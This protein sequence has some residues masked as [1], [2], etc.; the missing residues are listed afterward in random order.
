LFVTVGGTYPTYDQYLKVY[1]PTGTLQTQV[2]IPAQGEHAAH[3]LVVGAD[4]K[5]SI[6]NGVQNPWLSTYDGTSWSNLTYT[7]YWPS[8]NM[9]LTTYLW[10]GLAR[11]GNIV[12]ANDMQ[13]GS[14]G[15]YAAGIVRFNLSTGTSDR[16]VSG[17]PMI[18]T[19]LGQD[20]KLYGLDN[21]NEVIVYDPASGTQLNALGLPYTINGVG[22]NF[23]DLTVNSAGEI[24]AADGTNSRIVKF[25][26]SGTV[27]AVYQLAKPSGYFYP[28]TP[29]DVDL[30]PDGTSLAIGT[31]GA[32]VFQMNADF[33]NMT[34]YWT[35]GTNSFVAFQE[36]S[37]PFVSVSGGSITEG[38]GYSVLNFT[39][40][41][42]RA[43]DQIVS[44]NYSTADGTA[45]NGYDYGGTGGT[46]TFA[47]GETS[48]TVS[49]S[50]YGD[51]IVENDE[52]FTMTL[53]N[54]VN[55]AIA[56]GTAT[57]TIRNDDYPIVSVS[58][59]TAAEGNSGTTPFNFT[60][61]LSQP[62]PFTVFVQYST[63][64]GTA[65]AGSDYTAATQS[66]AF[67]SG[68]TSKTVTINVTGDTTME[69]D[70]TFT[71]NLQ[72]P[73]NCT[74]GTGTAT[75]T[76]TNDDFPTISIG[77]VAAFEGNSG[78][79]A[80]A[81]PLTLS[82]AAP[83][84]VTVNYST[85][86]GTATAGSDYTSATGS[87][88][89]S[90]GQTSK[91]V[92]VNVS[93]DTVI[94]NDETFTVTLSNPTNATIGTGTATGTIRNEDFPALGIVGGIAPEGNS[95]TTPL[96]FT[97]TL[98]EPAPMPL[99][100]T[101]T[102]SN[103]TATSGTD[104]SSAGG[105]LTF[106]PGETS[107]T[108][109]VDVTGDT[110]IEADETFTMTAY[111]GVVAGGGGSGGQTAIG[112]IINDDYPAVAVGDATV[113]EGNSG[114]TAL[115][116]T[117]TLSAPAPWP[118]TVDYTTADG[119]AAAG[120]DYVTTNG[121]LTFAAGETSKTVTVNVTGD[122]LVESDESI[123]LT[124]SNP[125][126]ATLATAAATGNIVND[127]YSVVSVAGGSVVEGDSGSATLA[128]TITLDQPAPWPV[129]VDYA[130]ANGT[131]TAGSD[132]T[133]ASGALTFAP[134][135]TSKT[136][137]IDVV[138]D[139]LVE[140]DETFTLNLSNPTGGTLA[141]VTGAGTI[142]NDD[143]P[144]AS[145]SNSSVVEGSSG[146][147]ALTFMVTLSQPAP[148]PVT[149]DFA[150]ADGTAAAGSDYEAA[151]G[152]LT[153]AAGETSKAITINVT[154]DNV[155]E[156]DET[157]TL[158]LSN[159][160]NASLEAATAAGTIVN[161]DYSAIS[162]G[163]A[164]IG[165]GNSGANALT[166]TVTLDHPASWAVT[167]N[168]STNDATATAGSDFTPASGTLSFAPGEMTRTVSVNV[169][170]DT[171]P[172][173]DETFS[174]DL[175]G[176]T[177]G[178]LETATASGTIIND[179]YPAV[180]IVDA[181]VIEGNSG[182]STLT[183]TVTLT[184]PA[185]FTVSVAYTT[186]DGTATAGSDYATA[187]GTITFAVGETSKT[188][189]VN[190]NGD[191]LVETD[192]TLTVALSAP[193]N[194]TLGTD[195]A[196]GAIVNDDLPAVSLA[197][198]SVT[199][200]NSGSTTITFTITLDQPA[201]WTV[202]VDFATVDGTAVAGS[203]YAA[204]S[205]TSTFAAGET[206]KTFTVNVNGD[207]LVEPDEAFTLAL[208]NPT[209]ATLGTATAL[210]AILND[211]FPVAAVNG[212]AVTEG[213]S[214]TTPLTFTVTLSQ[215]APWPVTVNFATADGSAT[216]GS[217]YQ[218]ASG[219]LTFAPGETSK[220]IVVN[221]VGDTA[222]ESDEAFTLTLSSPNNA[223]LGIATATGTIVNDD[224]P[225]VNVANAQ[226]TEGDIPYPNGTPQTVQMPFVISLS[227]SFT[228]P[229]DVSYTTIAGTATAGTDFTPVT[230]TVRI[231]PGLTQ[232][233]VNVPA[234]AD[235]QIEGIE[236]F[237]FRIT[238]ATF[239]TLGTTD[240]V[241]TIVDNDVPP[242]VTQ[243][244]TSPG[245]ESTTA[246]QMGAWGSYNPTGNVTVTWNF[247]DGTTLTG[248]P[249]TLLGGQLV[250]H[251][252]AD[253]GTYTVTVTVTDADRGSASRSAPVVVQN[254]APTVGGTVPPTI[255][256]LNPATFSFTLGDPSAA[257]QSAG[258][259]TTI[260]WGDGQGATSAL[261]AGTSNF[262]HVFASTGSYTV[263]AWAT[264]KD[265]GLSQTWSQTV[266]VLA[267]G[268]V[269]NDLVVAGTA[270]NDNITVSS[271]NNS[272]VVSLTYNGTAAGNFT[273]PS[274][275][276]VIVYGG[277]GDDRIE[278]KSANISGT[279]YPFPRPVAFHGGAGN[280]NLIASNQ[281]TAPSVLVGGVGND[282]LTGGNGADVLIGGLGV[283]SLTGG[284]G[285]DL[286]IGN[287]VA[288]E[289]DMSAMGLVRSEWA[290]TDNSIT[291]RM[292]H[293]TG[294]LPG[295]LNGAY[296]L[297]T[298]TI[299]EDSAIDDL[300]GSGGTDWFFAAPSGA[301]ADR[302]R[303]NPEYW[304]YL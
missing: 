36:P 122:T 124:L 35:G 116:F 198:G 70:E 255:V 19:T 192:E 109:M 299:S 206:S 171:A 248:S 52:T 17:W 75:G 143:Y 227:S 249:Q 264:D 245:V 265:G 16:I 40:N 115:A 47:P 76:I 156:F 2:T 86:N 154:G 51:T 68:Q 261:P 194:A 25:S 281:S 223:T 74:I 107:K 169:F 26:P 92:T 228:A 251:M 153:F 136:I 254:V 140:T 82:A 48:K 189:T 163:P 288:Y 200:G 174:L 87:V 125:T 80:F 83:F 99:Q 220:S 9:P 4:G 152:T 69:F 267:Y 199:E 127:D 100:V 204:A 211:D 295:G 29:T 259:N 10:G 94:E 176:P 239:A 55:A 97:I 229:I 157:L 45:T 46:V 146:T 276:S 155:A 6:F 274:A 258:F 23:R 7:G 14:E 252:Y 66:V 304:T 175:S 24:Y 297:N 186:S 1:G 128:F 279:N 195:T 162:V 183:Y 234:L 98:S 78:T 60:L 241:G 283:D 63:A 172:E 145:V 88:T 231:N 293:L 18:S 33:T 108:V 218:A 187:S 90:P 287:K 278:A 284:N 190:V 263:R 31:T 294:A 250:T 247:G 8:W 144:I 58:G 135:E 28:V 96:T 139:S 217:D 142:V 298:G 221:A 12:Y 193:T 44:V 62:A 207:T 160:T 237:T 282:T 285:N 101:Y 236:T 246:A 208:S 42:S 39:V 37:T 185:P 141:T 290:R 203:D 119:T 302:R 5:V 79:T 131:A 73:T 291:E 30:S 205:G 112:T 110:A 280:D 41:L 50:I 184:E 103:G 170:G 130:T 275:G 238:G 271:T 32:Y 93:G 158:T 262:S 114:T 133:A 233:T 191:S 243:V 148:W 104:Y 67:S 137:A 102:T 149:L 180:S 222:V 178:T 273:V 216:A 179:D 181:S 242:V 201:P 72:F 286:L 266:T 118:V 117:V 91:T 61:S 49:V 71:V 89:F 270:G 296:F 209:S 159:P 219:T 59:R 84:P 165:E 196:T 303:D 277:N 126:N 11:S 85:A 105:V 168:Y 256:A 197:G 212:G 272:S 56:V 121:T 113:T 81:F 177:G 123:T 38:S 34:W 150:T 202:T 226:A 21:Y 260:D 188:I 214:G 224:F 151:A 235:N 289:D 161:D 134:G 43:F 253:S 257:D 20:G 166:F 210:G 300:K 244:S 213:N 77:D 22:A 164:S 138:G 57:G 129:T 120:S 111:P 240:G 269:G 53:S 167:V 132:Y 3:D 173:E 27:L 292:D 15:T 54:P 147:S 64:N 215:P 65:T 182:I 95:G 13:V 232:A 301:Y 106:A 230:G 225:T 268:L